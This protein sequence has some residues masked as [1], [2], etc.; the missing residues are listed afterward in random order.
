M[1]CRIIRDREC[2]DCDYYSYVL[3]I[4]SATW[5]T[6]PGS[7]IAS[8]TSPGMPS[9]HTESHVPSP[10]SLALALDS[11][12][13]ASAHK[14]SKSTTIWRKISS[15]LTYT[16]KRCRYDPANP[17]GFSMALN[18]LFGFAATF[19]GREPRE[20]KNPTQ[21][22]TFWYHSGHTVL[23]PSDLEQIGRGL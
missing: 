14:S 18:L 1:M 6:A 3:L 19:T 16:P 15:S 23:Q 13:S 22:L 7:P 12:P 4:S 8:K 5:F 2:F 11:L 9:H 17:P 10:D 20:L 21:L